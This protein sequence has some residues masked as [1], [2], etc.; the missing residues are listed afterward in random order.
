MARRMDF[1]RLAFWALVLVVIGLDL[2]WSGTPV[3]FE[4]WWIPLFA[5]NAVALAL[6][7]WPMIRGRS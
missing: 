1:R 3:V 4:W 6:V 5:L 7:L 2:W